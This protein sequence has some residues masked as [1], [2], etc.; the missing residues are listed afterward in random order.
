ML[1]CFLHEHSIF[2]DKIVYEFEMAI[3]D[4]VSVISKEHGSE[5]YLE[6]VSFGHMTSHVT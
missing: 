4:R 1:A 3:G 2:K 6:R 5:L